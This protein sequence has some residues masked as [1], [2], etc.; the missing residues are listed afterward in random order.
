MGIE[1]YREGTPNIGVVLHWRSHIGAID[2][3]Y[4]LLLLL[5]LLQELLDKRRKVVQ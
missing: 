3:Y 1:S 4:V 2:W 5:P